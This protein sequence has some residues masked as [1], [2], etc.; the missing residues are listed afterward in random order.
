MA[1]AGA[2][3]DGRDDPRLAERRGHGEPRHDERDGGGR[4]ERATI[5]T[6]ERTPRGLRASKR[7]ARA[8]EAHLARLGGAR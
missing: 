7:E 3:V 6:I 2:A 8:L 1:A 5:T 4:S